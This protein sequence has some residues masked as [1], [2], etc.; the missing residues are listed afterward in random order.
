MKTAHLIS[1]LVLLTVACANFK[2]VHCQLVS[3]DIQ[4]PYQAIVLNDETPIQS[5]PGGAFYSTAKLSQGD[6][7]EV[8]R[9]DPGGWC[10]IRPVE[11]SFSL[12]PKST[13]KVVAENIGEVIDDGTRAWVGTRV[14]TVSQPLWQVKLKSG[15]QVEILGE[16]SWPDP[17]GHSTEWY[18]IAPPSG[19]FRWIKMAAIQLPPAIVL[20]PGVKRVDYSEQAVAD[21]NRISKSNQVRSRYDLPEQVQPEQLLRPERMKL[22][23]KAELMPN[24][25]IHSQNNFDSQNLEPVTSAAPEVVTATYIQE[26]PSPANQGWKPASSPIPQSKLNPS[27]TNLSTLPTYSPPTGLQVPSQSNPRVASLDR[28]VPSV[29]F[30]NPN[31]TSPNSFNQLDQLTSVA[32]PLQ[33]GNLS[34]LRFE[35]SKEMSRSPASWRIDSFLMAARRLLN[36]AGTPLEIE[37]INRIITKAEACRSIQTGYSQFPDLAKK[38]KPNLDSNSISGYDAEGWLKE[39]V[40]NGGRENTT[41]VL[42][43][44]AGKI[45]FHVAPAPGM[46]IKRY[47]N[48]KVGISGIRGFHTRLN[49]NHVTAQRLAK[50]EEP[51]GRF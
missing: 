38:P 14:E 24:G 19:E 44:D 41:Y 47:V 16:A 26:T 10:E 48:F 51:R 12:V 1:A 50:L 20:D 36:Q 40:Q 42:L 3:D 15:E 5:G 43:N 29:S 45:I 4:F 11:G 17:Q 39:M 7:V 23:S 37:S 21:A 13:L 2:P 25:N 33:I 35:W 49:L 6:T 9:H 22:R 34:E 30:A 32:T 27:S 31:Q 18:Q 8:Y 28:S 46:N